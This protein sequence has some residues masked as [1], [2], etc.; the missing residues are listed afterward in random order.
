ML[1]PACLALLVAAGQPADGP[2]NLSARLMTDSL[3]A[4]QTHR[5]ALTATLAEGWVFPEARTAIRGFIVQVDVPRAATL[6]GEV[7]TDPRML[8]RNEFLQAPYERLVEAGE[9]SIEF[10]VSAPPAAGEAFGLNIVAYIQKAGTDEHR[11]IRRRLE[12]PLKAQAVA[13]EGDAGNTHWGA[14]D[15]LHVGDKADSFALPQFGGAMVDLKDFLG[16]RNIII[17]TYRAHW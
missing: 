15:T 9:T 6:A 10:T 5:I 11:F 1:N 16:D 13:T 12:L 8:A 7:L 4:G 17:T 2:V 14:A 3:A